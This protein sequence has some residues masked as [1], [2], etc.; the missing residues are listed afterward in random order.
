[1]AYPHR[2][3]KCVKEPIAMQMETMKKETLPPSL[4][5]WISL[6]RRFLRLG[7]TA[8]G[9]PAIGG[10]MKKTFINEYGWIS[11]EDFNR[12][13]ALSSALPGPEISD[14]LMFLQE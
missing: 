2:R 11:E 8:Y 7:A 9:G 14:P 13:A 12:G 10:Q 1:L 6:F 3:E 5:F 4:P